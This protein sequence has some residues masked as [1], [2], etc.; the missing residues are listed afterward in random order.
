MSERVPGKPLARS[1][2]RHAGSFG[3]GLQPGA[4]GRLAKCRAVE[5]TGKLL[6][7]LG[8]RPPVG[9]PTPIPRIQKGLSDLQLFDA[10]SGQVDRHAGN[11]YVD[12]ETGTVTGIDDDRAFGQGQKPDVGRRPR[13]STAAC[14]SWWTRR[15]PTRSCC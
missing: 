11:I 5:R 10:I 8:R 4:D 13:T 9:R 2:T 6:Q 12:P 7:E 3:P 14:P 1:S 15:R